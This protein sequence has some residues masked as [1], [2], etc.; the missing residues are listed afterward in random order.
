VIGRADVRQLLVAGL[1]S[2]CSTCV[3]QAQVV[4]QAGGVVVLEAENFSANLSPRSAREWLHGSAIVPFSGTGYMEALPNGGSNLA[5]GNTSPELQFSVN[6]ADTGTHY[7]WLRGHAESGADDSAHVGLTSAGSVPITLTTLNAWQW[8][9]TNF[10]TNGAASINVAATGAQTVS[11][12][13]R[14]DGLRVD[15]VILTTAANFAPR[16]GNV[17]HIPTNAEPAGVAGMRQPVQSILPTTAV[18]IYSG[19]QFQG[20]GGDPADQVQTGSTVFYKRSTDSAWQ[21]AAM[22]FHSQAGNNKY[23]SA[24]IPANSFTSGD[25]V[26]YY[27][28]IPYRDRLPT[29]VYG[30]DSA[31]FRTEFEAQARANPF[32]FAV[33]WPLQPPVGDYISHNV[34]NFQ[35]RI[36]SESGHIALAGPDLNA[37]ALANVTTFAPPQV[38]IADRLYQIGSVISAAPIAGGMELVQSLAGTSVTT[39]LTFPADAVMRY[40]VVDWNGIAAQETRV[41]AASDAGE[42]FFGFGEKFNALDQSGNRVRMLTWDPAGAKGDQSYK[43]VPWFLSTRGY[44]FQLHGS[45]ES[46]F[47]MR[48]SA[49]DRYTI[50]NL[51]GQLAFSVYGGPKLTDVLSRYTGIVGRPPLPPPWTFG[52]WISSD[53][54]RNGGEVRYMVQKHVQLGIPASVV[55]FDSPWETAYN[56]FTWNTTQWSTGGTYEGVHYPGFATVG[57]MMQFLQSHGLKVICWMTPFIN[58]SSFNEGVPGQNLGQA[59]NYAEAA[60]N[61]Y[62]V[63]S[64][65]GG[66]PLVVPWWKGSGSPVDFTNPAAR[67]WWNA[68]LQSL[69]TQSNV[70]TANGQQEPVIGGFKTDD[71]ETSNG[72][73]VYIPTSAVYH[74]GR[75]GIEMRNGYCVEY[76]DTVSRVLGNDGV[77]FARGGFT[78]TQRFPVPWGGDNEPNFGAANGLQSVIVSGLSAAL[79]GYSI[80]SHDI[81]GYQNSNFESN[82]ADLFM[83]WSQYGAFTPVMQMHR[84]VNAGNLEQYPW[85]YGTAALANYVTYAKL[86]TQLFPYLYTYAQLASTTGLP[87]M[88]PL[89]LMHQTDTNTYPVRH[90]YLFGDELLVAPMNTPNS[91]SRGVYLPAGTWFDFWTNAE[92]TG[93]ANITWSNPD[94]TK[95]PLFVKAG[96]IVPMLQNVP[97][98]LNTANFVNNPAI[99]TRDEA[100]QFLVYPQ[101]NGSFTMYDGTAVTTTASAGVTTVNLSSVARPVTFKILAPAPAGVERNG[102]RLPHIPDAVEFASSSI[103]WRHDAGFLLVKFNHT[104]G[105]A[106]VTF[107]P[108]TSAGGVPLSWLQFH[109]I[110]DENADDDG[111]GLTNAQEYFAGTDPRDSSSR[112]AVAAA[113]R[114]VQAFTVSWPSAEGLPYRIQWKASLTDTTWISIV[115]DLT[116]TGAMMQWLDHDSPPPAQRFYRVTIP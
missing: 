109:K 25:I 34:G 84:Q 51:H 31:S 88:R 69:V 57:E 89:M 77:L 114:D 62:F 48:N 113:A 97:Q 35:A 93:G 54:W 55:V 73:N 2:L 108:G 85:G 49:P 90:T 43:P 87:I 98:T 41:S 81:G 75:T 6:F 1:L 64:S 66:P 104:G 80:W 7:V 83:R 50:Q 36:Y 39:R 26:Q 71:G 16:L 106:V 68:Q 28:R 56:D 102:V 29:F 112:F 86:H 11:L 105:N 96:A 17:W 59:A 92:H 70:T 30:S 13:M 40:E 107:S 42:R 4:N 47:D 110:G 15:R 53:I 99:T 3:V 74:D 20:S 32:T 12:W 18:Q 61:G 94:A 38:K 103:G 22:T 46:F 115:P 78:G 21:A 72:S 44:G 37:A 63:R 8:S 24:T 27:L 67:N 76:H 116:G 79:S 58:V 95:F 14:E 23:Y 10:N 5:A 19:N 111:D 65:P 33:E 45:A 52:T 9:N 101:A 82:R 91:T 60:A 100:L